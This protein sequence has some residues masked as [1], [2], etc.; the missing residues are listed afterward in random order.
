MQNELIPIDLQRPRLLDWGDRRTWL[1]IAL[2]VLI[3]LA[4]AAIPYVMPHGK[5]AEVPSI[6]V[7]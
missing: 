1:I 6:R 7:Y 5:T 2:L 4:M 3:G